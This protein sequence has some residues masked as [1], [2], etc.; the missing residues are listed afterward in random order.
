MK[1]KKFKIPV[2][3]KVVLGYGLIIALAVYSIWFIYG[4]IETLSKSIEISNENRLRYMQVGEIAANL[5]VAESISRDIIQNQKND[6]LPVFERKIDTINHIISK[7][8][9]NYQ[10]EE[11][12]K[13][14]DSF[15]GLLTQK[16]LNLKE[17][18]ELRQEA[19]TES[20]YAK[21]ISQL[22]KIDYNFEDENY[23][24]QLRNHDPGVRKAIIGLIEYSKQNREGELTQKTADSLINS[25][26]N[27]LNSLERQERR[28]LQ[29]INEKENELLENDQILSA[30]LQNIRHRI[31]QEEINK[32][33]ADVLH[34]KNLL[35]S[36]SSVI[37]ILGIVSILTMLVFVTM[38]FYDIHRSQKYRKQLEAA[39][40]YSESLLR[41]REQIMNTVTHD[42]RSP[43]NTVIGYS[44][45]LEKTP[46]NNQQA[47]YL[48]NLKTS[49][50]YIL[51]LVNDLLDISKL[52]SGTIRTEKIRFN[53]HT[54]VENAVKTVIPEN[55]TK[56]LKI[57]IAIDKV[58]DTDIL[59][60]AFRIQ[61]VLTNLLS[62]AY[63]FTEQGEIKVAAS[64]IS[65]NSKNLMV[66][67]VSDT[68][69]GIS[70]SLQNDIFLEF[71][72]VYREGQKKNEGFGLGLAIS[73]KIVMLL[74][75]EI[76]L[77]SE[78][79][80]GSVFTV[81]LPFD[82]VENNID[83]KSGI[84]EANG[85]VP[86]E[87]ARILIV[88]DDS[89]QR[90]LTSEVVSH[91][92]INNDSASGV[93]EALTF[94]KKHKYSMVL[95]DIQMPVK[96]GFEFLKFIKTSKNHKQIPVIA[97]SGKTDLSH[98]EFLNSG[99]SGHLLK[100]YTPD[101]LNNLLKEYFN[102]KTSVATGEVQ[103]SPH[104]NGFY[105]LSDLHYFTDGDNNSLRLIVKTFVE[106]SRENLATIRLHSEE[107][108]HEKISVVIHKMLPMFRQ[109]KINKV[110]PVM[111]KLE[112]NQVPSSEMTSTVDKLSNAIDE[113]LEM[114]VAE[115][116]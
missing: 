20:Y 80:K 60:D 111:E 92:G 7:L 44:S 74:G 22:K 101:T 8:K 23:E 66:I 24:W 89:T 43:L 84:Q 103:P 113:I 26:K 107:Q 56:N 67:E 53:L 115:V 31:E 12:H 106:N 69:I 42:L 72:Q 102:I 105:D 73:K 95:T 33:V 83:K 15:S 109:L 65:K 28:I 88:D 21:V 81:T 64:H 2:T 116:L 110:I 48:K 16:N 3:L 114:I 30:Q 94:L 63:K 6:S 14:L 27:V 9:T 1:K 70:K 86:V 76:T 36:T 71:S 5:F 25:M 47:Q 34:S 46:L 45:L 75:G 19:S 78:E 108:N 99:F 104:A 90:T 51:N 62:N 37:A 38:I 11:M 39:K 58:F 87:E 112:H 82:F 98:Q 4:Q 57:T 13:A 100:P 35:E 49:S 59:S 97:I 68:G 32:G 93:D 91:I 77:Q 41:N 50:D 18:L 61:Q 54:V 17:L 55:D 52:N 29:T 96:D 85:L 10:S 79:H 40:N